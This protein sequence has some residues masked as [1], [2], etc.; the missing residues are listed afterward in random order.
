MCVRTNEISFWDEKLFKL[1]FKCVCGKSHLAALVNISY[2]N[3]GYTNGA[4]LSE[5]TKM[6]AYRLY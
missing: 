2:A 3:L 6:L 5:V 1:I 4:T